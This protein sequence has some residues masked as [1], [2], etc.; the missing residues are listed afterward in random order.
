MVASGT[1][2]LECALLKKPMVI[3]YKTSWLTY[4]IAKA[5]IKIPYIGLVNIV[6]GKKVAE[7]L[8]QNEANATNIANAMET[9][10][11]HPQ[12]VKAL[13]AVKTSLGA[14]GASLRA[15]KIVLDEIK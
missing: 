11:C 14:P 4:A 7:E 2:T 6:A 5:V 1:A 8:I 12:I 9:A 13:A 10:L 3:I 15:A